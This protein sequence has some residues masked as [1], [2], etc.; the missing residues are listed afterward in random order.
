M[1]KAKM[2]TTVPPPP[3]MRPFVLLRSRPVLPGLKVFRTSVCQGR[4]PLLHNVA[5]VVPEDEV[6][7][8]HPLSKSINGEKQKSHK[9][10]REEGVVDVEGEAQPEDTK[11]SQNKKIEWGGC[12]QGKEKNLFSCWRSG[13]NAKTRVTCPPPSYALRKLFPFFFHIS[14]TNATRPSPFPRRSVSSVAPFTVKRKKINYDS[15]EPSR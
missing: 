10:Y 2:R 5:S 11:A 15:L 13:S 1:H 12:L 8:E 9:G 7:F 14:M 6:A 4:V 3:V